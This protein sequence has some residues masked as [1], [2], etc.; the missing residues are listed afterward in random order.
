MTQINIPKLTNGQIEQIQAMHARGQKVN[1]ISIKTG[2]RY[3]L[4][5]FHTVNKGQIDRVEIAGPCWCGAR[6]YA[7]GLCERHYKRARK[8]QR[9]A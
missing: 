5:W 6:H 1:A 9:A 2:I 7:R 4:V 3:S 8:L